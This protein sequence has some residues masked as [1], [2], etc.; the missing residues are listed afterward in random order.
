M[1][2]AIYVPFITRRPVW[3]LP[4]WNAEPEVRSTVTCANTDNFWRITPGASHDPTTMFHAVLALMSLICTTLGE[5]LLPWG[6][7]TYRSG[8][9]YG[10]VPIIAAAILLFFGI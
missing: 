5:G 9:N 6:I 10:V 8:R 3:P 4:R 7:V 1:V 2:T